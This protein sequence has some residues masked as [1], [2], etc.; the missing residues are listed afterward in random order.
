MRWGLDSDDLD[1][2]F[3]NVH[4]SLIWWLVRKN[5]K[6][7]KSGT[8]LTRHLSIHK[9]LHGHGKEAFKHKQ[10]LAAPLFLC[11]EPQNRLYWRSNSTW[12]LLSQGLGMCLNYDSFLGQVTRDSDL[13]FNLS[14]ALLDLD[15]HWTAYRLG[16]PFRKQVLWQSF[17][18]GEAGIF[19]TLK[20]AAF[21]CHFDFFA[22]GTNLTKANIVYSIYWEIWQVKT[23]MLYE[24]RTRGWNENR[25]RNFKN[26]TYIWVMNMINLKYS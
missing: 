13:R 10:R 21:V 17:D 3:K 15:C 8:P 25:K 23:G 1:S 24:R 18:S 16:W 5:E 2:S 7:L 9:S 26:L 11:M 22:Y 12:V 20:L 19:W 6:T 4:F 14:Q